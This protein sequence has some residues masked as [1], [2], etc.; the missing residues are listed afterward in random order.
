MPDRA[1]SLLHP[2]NFAA[3][4][5]WLAVALEAHVAY[6]SSERLLWIWALLAAYVVA[7]FAH[8]QN[9]EDYGFNVFLFATRTACALALCWLAV[10][11]GV[12][13]ALLVI[14]AA[15]FVVAFPAWKALLVIVTINI[16]LYFLLR[17]AGHGA[18]MIYALAFGGFQAFAALTGHYAQKAEHGRAA[19]A[20]TNANLLATRSLLADSARDAERLRVARELHDVAGHKLTALMLQLRALRTVPAFANRDEPLV[21]L[22]LSQDLLTDLRGVVRSLRDSGR[23]DLETAIQAL[24]APFPEPKLRLHVADNVQ[25]TDSTLAEVVLRIAQESLTNAARHAGAETVAISLKTVEE[26]LHL[27]IEDDGRVR[28]PLHEGFGLAG[29]RER[30]SERG[31]TLS[32]DTNGSNGGLRLHAV[33]PL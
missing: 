11:A 1:R 25:V 16:A 28:G 33:L 3:L 13:P 10:R 22:Q 4:L 18:P 27:M 6:A 8:S 29:M 15:Q 12:V 5:T 9:R 32:I 24:S 7:H 26:S 31:G 17:H 20:M 30:L 19:L 21:A 23:L 2:L 14:L